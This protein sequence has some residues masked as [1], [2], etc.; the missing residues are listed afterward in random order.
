MAQVPPLPHHDEARFSERSVLILAKNDKSPRLDSAEAFG[1][2]CDYIQFTQQAARD[3]PFRL[4]M[5][6]G[7]LSSFFQFTAGLIEKLFGLFRMA[8]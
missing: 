7:Q 8:A 4:V 5:V 2:P 1:D 6:I 3:P